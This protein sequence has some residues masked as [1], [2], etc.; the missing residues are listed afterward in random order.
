MYVGPFALITHNLIDVLCFKLVHC[1]E[2]LKQLRSDLRA[3]PTADAV[4]VK[5][6]ECDELRQEICELTADSKFLQLQLCKSSLESSAKRVH[7]HVQTDEPSSSVQAT[8]PS[9]TSITTYVQTEP[10]LVDPVVLQP[11]LANGVHSSQVVASVDQPLNAVET[12]SADTP[13]TIISPSNE[14][15][16]DIAL[17]TNPNVLLESELITMKEQCTQLIADNRKLSVRLGELSSR[18]D[19]VQ[20]K[21][22]TMWLVGALV[23]VI[24]YMLVSSYF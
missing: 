21:A 13:A 24:A 5:T 16:D 19:S 10:S 20:N 9:K 17:L 8:Q 3:R 12:V 6:K 22:S 4:A 23:A 15:A 11:P 2:E 7:S 18:G 1:Q 14:F